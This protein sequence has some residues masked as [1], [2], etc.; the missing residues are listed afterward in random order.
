MDR[1]ML[2]VLEE[3]EKEDQVMEA[4][5]WYDLVMKDFAN[6]QEVVPMVEDLLLRQTPKLRYL[7]LLYR[8]MRQRGEV[9]D[10]GALVRTGRAFS[11]RKH[12]T[13]FVAYFHSHD[14]Y[15]MIYVCQGHLRQYAQG[16]R[17]P[18]VFAGGGFCLMAP[19][20]VH[21]MEPAGEEDLIFKIVIPCEMFEAV[22]K[23]SPETVRRLQET[24]DQGM[25]QILRS[26]GQMR[27]LMELM[28]R[29][30]LCEEQPRAEVLQ[31]C[32][33]LIFAEAVRMAQ[34]PAATGK[35]IGRIE[36]ILDRADAGMSLEELAKRLG[37]S[38]DYLGRRIRRESGESF[39]RLRQ[40]FF[41]EK[42]AE[43]L[44]DSDL[45]VDEVASRLGYQ[46]TSSCYKLFQ[47]EYGIAP[48]AYRKMME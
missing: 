21:A 6:G 37:Y 25:I 31:A 23:A 35:L 5:S 42:A 41:L 17:V 45:S 19:G 9:V 48:G 3:Q 7:P 47:K 46:S 1:Q 29:E 13:C 16:A 28:A 22:K 8:T 20:M 18:T 38:P 44:L 34:S 26:G 14:F 30:Q 43:L 36:E 15:E 10:R 24:L 40:K 39:T 4:G 2:E 32:L 12:A 27:S 11:L 33:A